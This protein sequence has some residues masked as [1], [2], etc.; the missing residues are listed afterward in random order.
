M[1][2]IEKDATGVLPPPAEVVGLLHLMPQP[3]AALLGA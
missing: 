2:V 1:S 3:I